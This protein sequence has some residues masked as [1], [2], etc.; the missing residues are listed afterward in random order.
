MDKS[1]NCLIRLNFRRYRSQ[2]IPVFAPAKI[3]HRCGKRRGTS[4]ICR[5][6][7]IWHVPSCLPVEFSFPIQG[8]TSP[9]EQWICGHAPGHGSPDES[10]GAPRATDGCLG[11]TAP[12]RVS[13]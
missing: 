3:R 9:S 13:Q 8:D 2:Q 4:Q 12:W 7:E 1:A 10:V 5:L 11:P 6:R